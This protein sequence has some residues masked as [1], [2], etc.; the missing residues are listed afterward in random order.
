MGLLDL[1]TKL[2]VEHGSS[3]VQSKHIALFKDQLALAD[4][5]ITEL[6]TENTAL[7]SQLTNAETTIQKLTKEH[8]ELRAKEQKYEKTTNKPS[9]DGSLEEIKVKILLYLSK[10]DEVCANN[11]APILNSNEHT[12][13][14]HLEE[15]DRAQMVSASYW[16]DAPTSYSLAHN[17]RK[18]LVRNDLIT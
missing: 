11:I 2:V 13:E 15:L 5:K 17:G 8:E 6:E 16:A 14:F 18:Y 1:F 3:E 12:V 10:F 4:K 9:H 7:K